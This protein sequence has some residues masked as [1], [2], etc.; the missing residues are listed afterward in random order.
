MGSANRDY[1]TLAEALRGT[2]IRTV[3]IAK[4]EVLQSLPAHPELKVMC[5]LGYQECNA[6][7]A[8]ALLNVVPI[9]DGSTASGQVTFTTAM[10]LGVATV[11]TRCVGTVD[12][13]RD[14]ETGL[15][16]APG[17]PAAMRA[18]IEALWRDAELRRRL[19]EAARRQAEEEL[20]DEAAACHLARTI[21]EVLAL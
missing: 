4:P 1:T 7:L 17:D 20:S 16:V 5:G 19:G 18:A 2:G 8:G 12:Y 6:I 11:A 3:V 13:I 14:R 15:L 9:A 21:D 10:R